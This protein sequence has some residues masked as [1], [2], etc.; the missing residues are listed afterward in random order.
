MPRISQHR[1]EKRKQGEAQLSFRRCSWAVPLPPSRLSP[2]FPRVPG[3]LPS[4]LWEQPALWR[5]S[6]LPP[7]RYWPFPTGTGQ[8][9]AFHPIP[10]PVGTRSQAGCCHVQSKSRPWH[11]PPAI[12][13]SRRWHAGVYFASEH[14]IQQHVLQSLGC[15]FSF[16]RQ[17][18][19]NY[20]KTNCNKGRGYSAQAASAR[21]PFPLVAFKRFPCIGDAAVLHKSAEVGAHLLARL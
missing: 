12:G 5:C 17:Y 13:R 3:W 9:P 6:C 11:V 8:P 20:M 7:R 14:L 2:A 4:L 15:L 10:S 19:F 1:R 16:E 21:L 18:R